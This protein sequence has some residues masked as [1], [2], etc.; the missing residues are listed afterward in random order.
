VLAVLRRLERSGVRTDVPR[1]G[2]SGAAL[3]DATPKPRD[4]N[5]RTIV[6]DKVLIVIIF[7]R[8]F[9]ALNIGNKM[10]APATIF[11]RLDILGSRYITD[12]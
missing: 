12:R 2:D 8:Y 4:S 1:L 3:A 5:T 6:T 11:S 7:L 9:A 10:I